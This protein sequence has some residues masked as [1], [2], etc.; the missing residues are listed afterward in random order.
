MAEWSAGHLGN[1]TEEELNGVLALLAAPADKISQLTA[2]LDKENP[3]QPASEHER[4]LRVGLLAFRDGF[5]KDQRDFE[6]DVLEGALSCN[7]CHALGPA[8]PPA[9]EGG[10]P[11]LAGYASEQ[12]LRGIITNPGDDRYYG[13]RNDRMPAFGEQLRDSEI[14]MLVRWLRGD[15]RCRSTATGEGGD[16]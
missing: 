8:L 6:A 7:E 5:A 13:N 9:G 14:E 3:P 12:W 1:A 15:W 2:S 4:L 16:Q 11:D 10:G